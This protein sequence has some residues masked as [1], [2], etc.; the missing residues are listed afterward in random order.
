MISLTC[1]TPVAVQVRFSSVFSLIVFSLTEEVSCRVELRS[2]GKA[3]LEYNINRPN[4]VVISLRI[5]KK[6]RQSLS[7]DESKL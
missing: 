3:P 6:L 4:W 5:V 7:E 2:V 1:G